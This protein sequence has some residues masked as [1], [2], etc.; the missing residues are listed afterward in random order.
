MSGALAYFVTPHGFGHAARVCAVIEALWA[1]WPALKVEL[2]TTVPAW[3]FAESLGRPFGYHPCECDV[4]LVQ[5][6]SLAEDVAATARRLAGELPYSAAWVGELAAAVTALGCRAVVCDV[7]ALGVA[8]AER[9]QLPAVVVENFTW[10]WVYGAY[11]EHH[12][13]FAAASSYLGRLLGGVARRVQCEPVCAFVPG[14]RQVTPVWR[15]PRR[16]AAEVRQHLGVGVG[17]RLVL[18]TMGGVPWRWAGVERLGRCSEAVFVVPG[19]SDVAQR[20]DN[21]FLLPHHTG[22]FHPDLVRAADVVVGKLGYSTVAEVVG[23]GRP[24]AYVPRPTF[25]E[26]AV[27]EAYV[28][29]R[30]ACLAIPPER[31][32]TFHWVDE[33]LALAEGKAELPAPPRPGAGAVAEEI[34]AVTKFD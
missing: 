11:A 27:L 20:H 3:F 12:P 4:G 13:A 33:V 30:G 8:V 7:S 28:R 26:S 18:L 22:F 29:R 15:R 14:G 17:R 31:L 16:P 1:R 34:L 25:P 32:L 21:L 6:T 5:A 10:D 9:A 23:E 2:F 24:F 19:G